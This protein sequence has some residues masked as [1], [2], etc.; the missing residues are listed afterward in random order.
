MKKLVSKENL[1][2]NIIDIIMEEVDVEGMCDRCLDNG[3][4]LPIIE[5]EMYE[6]LVERIKGML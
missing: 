3:Q 2:K 4:V 5:P 1:A 6:K